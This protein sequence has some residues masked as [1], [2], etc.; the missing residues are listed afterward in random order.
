V[1]S[2]YAAEMRVYALPGQSVVQTPVS[3]NK[4]ISADR[5]AVD[6]ENLLRRRRQ[7]NAQGGDDS[8]HR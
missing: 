5:I 1:H 8:P 6:V 7:E 2:L 4:S 3:T